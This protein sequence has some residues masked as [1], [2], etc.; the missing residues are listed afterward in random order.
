VLAGA[1]DKRARHGRA[2]GA[3]VL[4][5]FTRRCVDEALAAADGLIER[6]SRREHPV[7]DT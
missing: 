1:A 2:A 4:A 5:A 6:F 7:A 3:E